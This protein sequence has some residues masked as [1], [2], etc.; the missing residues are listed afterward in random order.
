MYIYANFYMQ[1]S[2]CF[3]DNNNI[4]SDCISDN[5]DIY[6]NNIY[7]HYYNLREY[8]HFLLFFFHINF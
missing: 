6:Y 4:Y 3:S 8:L 7:K 1:I 2:D 5:N